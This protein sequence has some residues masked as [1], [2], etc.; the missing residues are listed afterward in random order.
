MSEPL[1]GHVTGGFSAVSS[2]LAH[3]AGPIVTMYLLPL[4]LDR[5]LY[6]GTC[7]LYFFILNSAK[8][9]AYA[10][11]GMF[12]DARMKFTLWFLPLVFAGAIFG[13]WVNKKMS[14]RIFL[15]CRLPDHLRSGLVHPDRRHRDAGE[16][17]AVIEGGGWS[18]AFV[19]I[20]GTIR[21]MATV[22]RTA[23]ITGASRGIG[24][25]IALALAREHFNV[26]VNYAAN[27]AAA[28]RVAGQIRDLGA[29]AHLVQADIASAADRR[30]LVDE[31][32]AA[33]GPID[34]LV[35]NAGIA[36]SRRADILVAGE[37]S[38]DRIIATNLKGP[39]FLTQLVAARM[40]R[41]SGGGGAGH[42][43]IVN[44]SSISAYAA[45]V[46]R[47]DYCIAKAGLSMVTR[48]W[49]ARLAGRASM[50]TKSARAS[51]VPT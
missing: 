12:S 31:A 16:G 19:R 1:R 37:E 14:D 48:L 49:A 39:Y 43:A 13:L 50:S 44:I 47:G 29:R 6:V 11:S 10:I 24:R 45:S 22:N 15:E 33:F 3:A 23:L 7:A 8:L 32:L 38:F 42:R 25:G 28:R 51:S 40:M 34:L 5:R 35:N 21:P 26:V 17:M 41:D 46:D 4:K 20:T 9:P 2:T 30:R 27:Q 18:V 36:P